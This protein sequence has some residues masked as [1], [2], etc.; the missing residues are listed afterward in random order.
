MS[1]G[2]GLLS[3][4]VKKVPSTQVSDDRYTFLD[5]NNAEPDLGVP[6]QDEYVLISDTLGNRSWK[7]QTGVGVSTVT[8]TFVGTDQNP[9]V[10]FSKLIYGSAKI[11]IQA[12]DNVT[13]ERQISEMLIVHNGTDVDA[14]E[15]GIIQT[16]G[17][18][19][20]SFDVVINGDDVVIS[21]TNT[22]ANETEYRVARTLIPL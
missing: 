13:G 21:A 7:A 10:L 6:D 3:R 22:T 19:I 9:L 18:S 4:R 1:N 17:I 11:T 8:D 16:N 5:L 20:A 2:I 12:T 15:F 14:T